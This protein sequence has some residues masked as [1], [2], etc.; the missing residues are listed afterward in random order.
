M[1]GY[2]YFKIVNSNGEVI[3]I[4]TSTEPLEVIP[5]DHIQITYEEYLA[6]CEEYGF[7]PR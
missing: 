2:V 7:V 1:E 4:A 5:E 3:G 6:I